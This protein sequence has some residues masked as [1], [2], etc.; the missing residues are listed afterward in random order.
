MDDSDSCTLHRSKDVFAFLFLSLIHYLTSL[1][2]QLMVEMGCLRLE[3]SCC[4]SSQ[5]NLP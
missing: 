4:V 1:N 3:A 5:L 2:A